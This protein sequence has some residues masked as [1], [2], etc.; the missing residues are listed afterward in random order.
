MCLVYKPYISDPFS[1]IVNFFNNIPSHS[2]TEYIQADGITS[3][4]DNWGPPTTIINYSITG[5]ETQDQWV[6]PDDEEL[7]FVLFS[8]TYPIYITHYTLKTR[9][10][11]LITENLAKGWDVFCSYDNE[12]FAKIDS[13]TNQDLEEKRFQTYECDTPMVCK[14]IKIKLTQNSDGKW[15]FHLSRVE[16]FGNI[17]LINKNY[18]CPRVTCCYNPIKMNNLVHIA[19]FLLR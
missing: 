13:Q 19:I 9:S 8:L 4:S 1:G 18:L 15:H 14:Y 16:F 2:F 17:I 11:E 7:S 6:T 5:T 3:T 12:T 10:Q